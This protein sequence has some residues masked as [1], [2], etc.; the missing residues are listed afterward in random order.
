MTDV[1]VKETILQEINERLK[2]ADDKQT[3]DD[4]AIRAMVN[5][6]VDALLQNGGGFARKMRF[7]TDEGD[8]RL[9]GSKFGRWNLSYG[10]IE[11]LYDLEVAAQDYAPNKFKGPSEE[12]RNAFDH[13]QESCYYSAEE[14]RKIDRKAIDDV[15][16][17]VPKTEFFGN[18]RAL[19]EQGR[20][21][22]TQAYQRAI[23]AMDTAESGYG[24][25]LIGAQY[26]SELWDAARE[27]SL[28][29]DMLRP[30]EMTDPTMY[31]PVAAD[32]PEMLFVSESTA[33][34]AA[35][36]ATS[37]TGSN[38]VQ[39]DAKKFVIHQVW[40]D[41]LQEDSIIAFIPMIRQQAIQS[42]AFYSD[43]LVI[44][45]DTTNAATG[46]I[47]LDDAN[48]IDTKHYLAVDGMR[49]V[50]LVDNTNNQLNMGGAITW[51]A[52]RGARV[53]MIDTTNLQNWGQ[54]KMIADLIQVCDPETGHE[55]SNLDEVINWRISNNR[56]LL[57]G[58]IAEVSGNPV[59]N[60]MAIGKTEADGKISDTAGN[61]TKG[62]LLTFNKRGFVVG[63]RRRVTTEIERSIATGQ[64]LL[65]H[66]LRLGF[67]RYS[68]TGAASGIEAADVIFNITV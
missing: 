49:R 37:K 51:D 32:L 21:Q 67:G 43:S 1:I 52:L 8:R 60:T 31:I 27:E 65:V 2:A 55:I 24:S 33:A 22:E 58:Q 4:A 17:R 13:I 36:Y 25:Q 9:I 40:S 18:D 14:I 26:V 64:T 19:A 50:G 11:L 46:N 54:P 38:R 10:D 53:R 47:N 39:V 20:W 59:I 41:E 57:P 7:G 66:S 61:N 5:E 48:P 3:L 62:Q 35:D 44:N 12:L 34:N 16:P 29:F 15:F 63:W 56:P 30:I 68:A 6:Q 28:V 45:G 23:R 42:I